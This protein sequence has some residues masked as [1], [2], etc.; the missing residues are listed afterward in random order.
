MIGKTVAESIEK[1]LKERGI[2]KGKF[3]K[4]SGITSATFSNWKRGIYEPSS[5]QIKKVERYL[6]IS[7]EFKE[8]TAPDPDARTVTDDDIK[9][10]FF[11]TTDI[12][13]ELYAEVKRYAQYAMEQEKFKKF[14]QKKE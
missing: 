4:E 7:F 5:E 3:Y 9:F 11:G 10:A 8:K 14:H 6:G 1:T 12:T 2:T 13:D